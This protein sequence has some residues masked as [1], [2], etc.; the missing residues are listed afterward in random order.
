MEAQTGL[1]MG[2]VRTLFY[3]QIIILVTSLTGLRSPGCG[4]LLDGPHVQFKTCDSHILLLL[5][6]KD[7]QE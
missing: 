4:C 1:L 2:H 3:V 5:E 7:L 6:N